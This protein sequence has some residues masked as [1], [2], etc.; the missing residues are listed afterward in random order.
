[1]SQDHTGT[2]SQ[3]KSSPDNDEAE[4]DLND[5]DLKEDDS[6]VDQ[7]DNLILTVRCPVREATLAAKQKLRK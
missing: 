4:S 6:P 1:M 7:I 5:E 3:E 2:A